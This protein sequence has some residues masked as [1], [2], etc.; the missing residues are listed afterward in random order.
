MDRA[1][2]E[3]RREA[4]YAGR[5]KASRQDR[6]FGGIEEQ[7]ASGTRTRI[8]APA[9]VESEPEPATEL[10]ARER[11]LAELPADAAPLALAAF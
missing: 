3:L 10:A 11:E 6:A 4:L 7:K 5:V 9:S 8:A 2:Q 1:F